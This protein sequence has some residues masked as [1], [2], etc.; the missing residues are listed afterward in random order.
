M[1][2]IKRK[3]YFINRKL[4][5][6]LIAG[7]FLFVI[8]GCLFFI[9]LLGL[10]SSD[11]CEIGGTAI[12]HNPVDQIRLII[13]SHLGLLAAGALTLLV[14][15]I[16]VTHRIAG[17]LFRFE[18]T[19][20]NMEAGHLHDIISLRSKDEGQ[21]LAQKI[22]SFNRTLS[23]N[24]THVQNHSIAMTD[25]IAQVKMTSQNMPQEKR[26]EFNSLLW[27]LEEKNK[28]IGAICAYYRVSK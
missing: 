21:E 15:A 19:L 16:S 13:S 28:K 27:S 10:F 9:L 12:V 8:C 3:H 1:A 6:R 2:G 7:Y 25:L 20:S 18:K 5:G 22:N 17:P 24:L 26:D 11:S 4:Q 14:C 23:Q